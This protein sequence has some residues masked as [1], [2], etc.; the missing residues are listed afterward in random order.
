MVFD[1]STGH[2]IRWYKAAPF[3][4]VAGSLPTTVIVGAS[5]VTAYDNQTGAVRWTRPTGPAAQA[6]QVDGADLCVPEQ[7]TAT[8]VG[9]G[10]ALRRIDLN[11]GLE[12]IVRPSA[13]AFPGNSLGPSTMWCCSRKRPG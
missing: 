13:A 12:T 7:R 1:S 2:Q 4:A 10:T 3:G 5:A 11:D 8:S 9:A 6:W